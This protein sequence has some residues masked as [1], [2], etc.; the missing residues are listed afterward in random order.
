LSKLAENLTPKE[1]IMSF[2]APLSITIQTAP[3]AYS[4]AKVELSLAAL[5][6]GQ[7]PEEAINEACKAHEEIHNYIKKAYD[8]L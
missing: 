3:V 2:K 1:T 4:M 8:K 6:D 5:D 7:T